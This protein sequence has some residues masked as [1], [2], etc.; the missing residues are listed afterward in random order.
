LN[1]HHSKITEEEETTMGTATPTAECIQLAA[2]SGQPGRNAVCSSLEDVAHLLA[3][4][5]P[6]GCITPSPLF[7]HRR[8]KPGEHV[9]RAGQ[10]FDA[11]YLVNCGFLKTVSGDI[12]GNERVLSFPM[13]GNLLGCDGI[14]EDRY[15]ADAIALTDCDLIVLPFAQLLGIGRVE[16][17]LEHLICRVISRE[18]MGE[19]GHFATL[20]ALPSDA[21]V[22]RFLAMQAQ[23]HAAMGFSPRCFMLRMTRR[24]I[25]SYLGLTL[26]TVSRALSALDAAGVVKVDQRNIEILKPEV[27]RGTSRADAPSPTRKTAP[28]WHEPMLAAA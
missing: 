16:I 21:R 8:V 14:C 22:A 6:A 25:G 18:I 1:P 7:H 11:L 19:H 5:L 4:D 13:K 9:Y 20:S 15:S 12:E 26:E 27:L 24:E 28:A 3:I 17:A 10:L 2:R 23:R